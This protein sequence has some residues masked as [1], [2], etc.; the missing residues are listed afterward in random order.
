MRL[1]VVEGA[2][3]GS[4]HGLEAPRLVR[5]AL[6]VAGVRVADAVPAK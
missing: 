4:G 6:G 3:V 5:A 2:A 1:V